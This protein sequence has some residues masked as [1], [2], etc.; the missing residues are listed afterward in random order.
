MRL[1]AGAGPIL[2]DVIAQASQGVN[3]D[4]AEHLVSP[5]ASFTHSTHEQPSLVPVLTPAVH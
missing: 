2:H 1:L 3:Q 4:P 5:Q